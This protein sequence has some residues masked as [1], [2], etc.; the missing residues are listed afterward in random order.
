MENRVSFWGFF[1]FF[2]FFKGRSIFI[3]RDTHFI[4][5]VWKEGLLIYFCMNIH[6]I[7]F[8]FFFLLFRATSAAYGSSQG[9]GW[10]RA[11][12]Y[13]CQSTPQPQQCQI[14]TMPANNTT[15]QGQESNLNPHNPTQVLYRWAMMGTPIQLLK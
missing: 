9:R 8:S 14:Q 5:R 12:S 6:T 2:F 3:E 1:S 7:F 10:I 15:E 13:S 4:G 11:T